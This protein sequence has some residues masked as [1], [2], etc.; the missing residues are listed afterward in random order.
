MF[1]CVCVCVCV[2][3]VLY[4]CSPTCSF[5]YSCFLS[6]MHVSCECASGYVVN[7]S[8]CVAVRS[9]FHLVDDSV[10]YTCVGRMMCVGLS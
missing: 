9:R 6:Y 2:C 1:M 5:C 8:V 4:L 10:C 7:V 3:I